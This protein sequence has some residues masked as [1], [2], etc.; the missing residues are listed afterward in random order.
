MVEYRSWEEILFISGKPKL[1]M[2][3]TVK[4][5]KRTTAFMDYKCNAVFILEL[6]FSMNFSII[7]TINS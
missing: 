4:Q 6:L 3:E 5:N 7:F 2:F 1:R